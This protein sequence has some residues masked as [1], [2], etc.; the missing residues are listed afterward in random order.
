MI[1]QYTNKHAKKTCKPFEEKM[2]ILLLCLILEHKFGK[3]FKGITCSFFGTSCQRKE[4]VGN[5]SSLQVFLNAEGTALVMVYR[6]Q[7]A[8]Y[9]FARTKGAEIVHY[10]LLD[11]L[12]Y[13]AADGEYYRF[14]ALSFSA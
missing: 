6:I 4:T 11:F 7:R 14:S 13:D 9:I 2:P 1:P 10:L 12:Q 8:I 5:F 3:I